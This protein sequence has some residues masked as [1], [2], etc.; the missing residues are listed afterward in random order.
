MAQVW[1]LGSDLHHSSVSGHAV[2]VTHI[3]KE[4]DWQWM[5]AQ[6]VLLRKKRKILGLGASEMVIM[7]GKSG[8]T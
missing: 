4:E 7:T 2:A 5:L 6:A 8:N 3:E 1:F